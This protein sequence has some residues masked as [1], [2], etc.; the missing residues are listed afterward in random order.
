MRGASR[1]SSPSS[2]RWP[3][4]DLRRIAWQRI[5][6]S[7]APAWVPPHC[8]CVESLALAMCDCAE[9]QGL[10]VDRKRVQAAS[11]LHDVGRS[12]TQDI[13]HASKGA[14]MLREEGWDPAIVLMVERHTGGGIDANEARTLGLP[15]KDYTPQTLEERI[16]CHADNLY[17]GDKRLTMG[18]LEAKYAAKRLPHAWA[19][20]R[21]LHDDLSLRLGTDLE[22]LAPVVLPP[23]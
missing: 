9:Q 4:P 14:A 19:K 8:L 11:I 7:G 12:V 23:L 5:S 10:K 18:A 15:M 20:I 22:T 3:L 16:V 1:N 2:G 17:S 6:S 13:H 21:R